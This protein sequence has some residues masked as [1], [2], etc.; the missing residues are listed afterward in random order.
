[1]ADKT[2][3]PY[4]SP[5]FDPLVCN[6]KYIQELLVT[7]DFT[8]NEHSTFDHLVLRD[9]HVVGACAVMNGRHRYHLALLH[10]MTWVHR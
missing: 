9:G 4:T 3:F 5:E 8:F 7:T 2:A 10:L 1:M 6:G